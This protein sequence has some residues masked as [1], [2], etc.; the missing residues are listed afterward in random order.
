MPCLDQSV[1]RHVGAPK[2]KL[3][4][5]WA[6]WAMISLDCWKALSRSGDQLKGT[7]EESN[8]LKGSMAGVLAKA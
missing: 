4:T 2:V 1:A 3:R 8:Y 5:P 6:A 7:L